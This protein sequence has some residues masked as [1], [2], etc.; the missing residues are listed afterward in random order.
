MASQARKSF[1]N[2]VKDVERL[3][4]LHTQ[5]GGKGKGRRYG[6]EVLNKSAIVL[7]TAFWEAY[8]EDIA[9]E[10]LEHIVKNAKSADALPKSLK[11]QIAKELKEDKNEISIWDI[12]DDKWRAFL[13]SRL[14]KL[15]E[16]RNTTL[17]TPKSYNI[18]KLFDDAVGITDIASNWKISPKTDAKAAA[19]KLD[20]F[21]TLR[22]NIAHRGVDEASVKK[23]SVDDY[24]KLVKALAG[25]TGGAVNRHVKSV[26]GAT[27][28]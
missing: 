5:L 1:D 6:L 18:N 20:R 21:V 2:H 25:K 10:G 4:Q 24:L 9:A 28:W 22:G 19:D 27:L 23:K 14:G 11:K 26:T 7:I 3:L 12:S 13:T 17:N 15:Q 8:C 16:S